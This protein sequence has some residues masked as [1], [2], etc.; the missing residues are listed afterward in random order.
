MAKVAHRNLEGS[1]KTSPGGFNMDFCKLCV[2]LCQAQP[3]ETYFR[4]NGMEK[5]APTW[6]TLL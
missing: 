5:I 3:K 2:I 1:L 4:H 6:K